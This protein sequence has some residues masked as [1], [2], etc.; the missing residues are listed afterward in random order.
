MTGEQATYP[1]GEAGYD[2][3]FFAEM[4]R[5]EDRHFWFR[6]RNNLITALTQRIVRNWPQPY[7]VLE[8]GCGN[9]NVLRHLVRVC[10]GAT[11]VGMDLFAEGLHYARR[12]AACPVVQADAGRTPFRVG[13]HLVGMFDVLEHTSD[14]MRVLADLHSLL[15]PGGILLLTVPAGKALWSYFDE[16]A[17]HC[18]RYESAELAEKL[19]QAGFEIEMLT[20]CMASIYPLVRFSRRLHASKTSAGKEVDAMDAVRSQFAIVPVVNSLL[21]LLLR[22]EVAWICLGMRFGFG[23]SLVAVARRRGDR[24]SSE[25]VTGAGSA[26]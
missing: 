16:A 21:T 7:R 5:V 18:R 24:A 12:R 23:T 6:A 2:A 1:A 3:V 17:H 26:K 22:A 10:S 9:G 14:D 20:H 8:V 19:R 4:M 11:I 25:V 15:E 13:F